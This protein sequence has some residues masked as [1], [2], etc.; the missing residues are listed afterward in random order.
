MS[1]SKEHRVRPDLTVFPTT[2][3]P[4]YVIIKNIEVRSL[5]AHHLFPFTGRAT[6]AYLPKNFQ[7]GLSK[8]QRLMDYCATRLTDQETISSEFLEEFNK[9]TNNQDIAIKI[10]CVHTCMSARGVK[11]H[12]PITTTLACSSDS[13]EERKFL[14]DLIK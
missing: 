9:S 13:Y 7:V 1:F 2:S 6:V 14:L 4:P 10:E 11:C 12:N 5:C 8:M 3:E